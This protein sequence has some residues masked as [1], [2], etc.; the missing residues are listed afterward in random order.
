[1]SADRQDGVMWLSN[2]QNIILWLVFSADQVVSGKIWEQ[3]N[4]NI[5]NLQM[6][7]SYLI[8]GGK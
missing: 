2:K 8:K 3:E 7:N 5:Y 6:R 4:L 1:M